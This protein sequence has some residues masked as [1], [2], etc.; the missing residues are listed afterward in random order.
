MAI[1]KEIFAKALQ[2]AKDETL[3]RKRNISPE[4]INE[5]K[6]FAVSQQ[7]EN[8]HTAN[9]NLST[10]WL[11]KVKATMERSENKKVV[12]NMVVDAKPMPK[13]NQSPAPTP[14]QNRR[15]INEEEDDRSDLADQ[16]F[17]DLI[18]QYAK[19]ARTNM[20][21]FANE[22][23]KATIFEAEDKINNG[24]NIDIS[25]IKNIVN[26]EMKRVIKDD[27]KGYVKELVMECFTE[28]YSE[29]RIKEVFVKLV[30]KAK[31]PK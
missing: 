18:S 7:L 30:Q 11:D 1:D 14:V 25:E 31:S 23:V 10:E 22:R 9:I 28:I 29:Q 5:G 3:S 17:N 27:L 12:G 19:N 16:K 21:S 24:Q 13:Y 6:S 20:P 2:E 4:Q 8:G 15:V 26:S